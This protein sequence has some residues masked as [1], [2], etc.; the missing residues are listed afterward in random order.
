MICTLRPRV[1]RRARP[2]NALSAW[3][4]PHRDLGGEQDVRGDAPEQQA[5]GPTA[6]ADAD[7]ELVGLDRLGRHEESSVGSLPSTIWRVSTVVTS[8]SASLPCRISSAPVL[9]PPSWELTAWTVSPAPTSPRMWSQ[10]VSLTD[11]AFVLNAM[12]GAPP[13]SG[14]TDLQAKTD[15]YEELL[16][17]AVAT[18]EVAP[19]D[20]TPLATAA[21]ECA[22][23]ARS[24]LEDGRHFRDQDDPVNALAAF[25]YG[26]AWLDAGARLGLFDVPR[27][28]HLF[29]V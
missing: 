6:P 12:Y 11:G 22:E 28:G 8:L 26:H 24:Y 19:P 5:A 9:V 18:A 1:R 7:D 17:E 20:G 2:R 4:D 3:D 27:E 23:M 14:M 29:T 10:S 15:Q 25:S 13:L 16:V 21:G